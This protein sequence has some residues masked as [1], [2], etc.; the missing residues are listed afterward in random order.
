MAVMMVGLFVTVAPLSWRILMPMG[1]K[2]SFKPIRVV[3]YAGVCT[4]CVYFVGVLVP[5]LAG[6]IK[7]FLTFPVATLVI[8][9][10]LPDGSLF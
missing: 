6:G 3:I 10:N 4:M 8:D 1:R 7:T 9:L 2:V 5:W